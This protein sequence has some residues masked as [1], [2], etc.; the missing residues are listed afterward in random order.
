M[1]RDAAVRGEVFWDDERAVGE[2]EPSVWPPSDLVEA[3]SKDVHWG[4]VFANI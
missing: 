2:L 1:P 3:D 4:H